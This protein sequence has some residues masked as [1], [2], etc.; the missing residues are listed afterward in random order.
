MD[1]NGDGRVSWSEFIS[2]VTRH[3]P[4]LASDLRHARA[5]QVPL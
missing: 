4:Q 3:L 2:S 5:L 1:S